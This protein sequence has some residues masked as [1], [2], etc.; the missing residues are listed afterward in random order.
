V[1]VQAEAGEADAPA[2]TEPDAGPDAARDT[3]PEA[4]ADASVD[5]DPGAEGTDATADE[6]GATDAGPPDDLA[7]LTAST[8]W[9]IFPG[10]GYRY[11]PSIVV[12]PDGT[13]H[14]WTCSPGSG[15]AWD[16][17][18][19]RRSTDG[20][21]TWTPDVVALQ[22]TPG[23]RDALAACDPG[24]VRS[25]G[26]WYLGYTSTEDPRGTD[27]DLY[28][29]RAAE[30]AGPYDKWNGAGWGGSP[31]PVIAYDGDPA[32]YGIGEPSLVVADRL[33]VYY[34]NIDG[35]GHTDVA[36]ADPPLGDDWP[37]RLV[38]HGTAIVRRPWAED[39]T[40]VKYVDLLGRFVGVATV[41]RFGPNAG[42]AVYQS[43]D[44]LS[45]EP[46]AYRGARVQHGAH[47]IG[48][49][50]TPEGHVDAAA[51]NFVAYAYAPPGS[52]WGDWPTFV[53]PVAV[54]TAP[55]GTVVYGQVSSIVG[56]ASGDWNW[57]GPKAWDGDPATVFSSDSHGGTAEAEEWLWVDLGAAYAVSGATIT[58]R[59]GGLGFPIDFSLQTSGDAAAW[60]DVPGETFAGFPNP[61]GTPVVRTFS[62][63][64]AARYVRLR[65][66]RLGVDDFG[67]HYLQLAEFAPTVGES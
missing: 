67:N 23:G 48:L 59:A 39:S 41:D 26:W 49:S 36:T 51:A 15:G 3:L 8:G 21:R 22:P 60:V 64:V 18:R 17:V 1:E 65:A 58:P 31:Q 56:G 44:G 57:S 47:N 43:F 4:E 13:A 20:G 29:A 12:E 10:G 42:V 53:D 19:Y 52:G 33:F 50:G 25:G 54:S 16:Y 11:G 28:V 6:E 35:T 30:P 37:A 38:R 63:P 7:R 40:D 61:G 66:T 45:F 34:T 32:Q 2:E 55:R 24:V 46:A 9:Q 14:M 5:G 27:N 62:A